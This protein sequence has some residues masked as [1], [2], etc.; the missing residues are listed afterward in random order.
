MQYRRLYQ[1]GGCYFFTVTTYGRQPIFRSPEAVELLRTAFRELRSE[2]PFE[3]DAAVV[4]PDHLHCIWRLPDGDDDFSNRFKSIKKRFT[5]AY[6][7]QA[8]KVWQ[9][10]F[11]EHLIRDQDDWRRHMDYIHYNPVKHGQVQRPGD[12]PYSSFRRCVE[13]GLYVPDWGSDISDE[14]LQMDLE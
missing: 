13:K 10:R 3:I 7:G 1:E 8:G 11:W 4:L 14:V 9:K 12:W 6:E 5:T 2:R